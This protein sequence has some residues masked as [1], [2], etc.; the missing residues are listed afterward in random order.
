VSGTPRAAVPHHL[1]PA[2]TIADRIRR[3]P[4]GGVAGRGARDQVWHH[5]DPRI[6]SFIERR[7]SAE[8]GRGMDVIA[9]LEV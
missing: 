9:H 2:P 3:L 5:P 8:N 4:A 1:P 6:R 7:L